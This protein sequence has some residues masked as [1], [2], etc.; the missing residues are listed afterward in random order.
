VDA[1][2]VKGKGKV[3]ALPGDP[4]YGVMGFKDALPV[5]TEL[6]AGDEFLQELRKVSDFVRQNGASHS[7]GRRDVLMTRMQM[8]VDQD[9]LERRLWAKQEKVKAEHERQIKAE[10]DMCA[11]S[12]SMIRLPHG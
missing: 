9:T 2:K 10:K 11:V 4:E 7:T 6:L 8:K 12:R 1:G 3:R 5:L